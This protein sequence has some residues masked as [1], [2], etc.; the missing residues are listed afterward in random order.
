MKAVKFIGS[1]GAVEASVTDETMFEFLYAAVKVSKSIHD[2]M[3]EI[4]RI[5]R[6][7]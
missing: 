2:D 6:D 3:D 1:N 4:R 5:F 7:L